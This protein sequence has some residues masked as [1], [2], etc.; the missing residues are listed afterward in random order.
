MHVPR[1]WPYFVAITAL[2]VLER[3][4]DYLYMTLISTLSASRPCSNGVTF[5]SVSDY[6]I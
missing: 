4:Y 5:L 6:G 1:L 3:S 2:L